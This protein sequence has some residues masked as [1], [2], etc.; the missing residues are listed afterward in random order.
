MYT[1]PTEREP[2]TQA[3]RN[4]RDLWDASCTTLKQYGFSLDRQDRR[5]GVITT[6]TVS[7]GHGLEALWR[8]DA[9]NVF[10]L[11]ENTT[12]N[13]LRAARVKIRRLP[14]NPESFDFRVEVR[15]ART[16]RPQPQVTNAVEVNKMRVSNLPDLRFSDLQMRSLRGGEKLRG[17]QNY[18][19]PLGEDE[20]LAYRIDRSIR[21]RAGIADQTIREPQKDDV[22]ET[23]LPDVSV[24]PP[25]RTVIL[26]GPLEEPQTAAPTSQP[27]TAPSVATV[28]FDETA[29]GTPHGQEIHHIL[30]SLRT[31]DGDGK[32]TTPVTM[33]FRLRNV[34]DAPV[35]LAEPK[36]GMT[37]FVRYRNV[38]AED[39][40]GAPSPESF[41]L[42]GVA[43]IA[44]G[45]TL[46]VPVKFGFGAAGEYEIFFRYSAR[47][48][49]DTNW[50][51][52]LDSNILKFTITG[53]K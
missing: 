35:R 41:E 40:D 30:C 44:P 31:A 6:Y 27:T 47:P 1:K 21:R 52:D 7:G 25:K 2:A 28:V 48:G 4:F 32:T 9:S 14:E 29:P 13:I 8:K 20:E 43:E 34:G 38:G 10:Y 17:L 37:L 53:V 36:H 46:D 42:P 15:M 19:V 11:R 50:S 45:K 12:Q 5:E 18:I 49:R 16:D 26:A 3:E 23:A 33:I 39:W 51:G 24:K 22:E